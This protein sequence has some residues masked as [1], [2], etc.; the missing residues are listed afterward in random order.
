MRMAHTLPH[1][2]LDLPEEYGLKP[3]LLPVAS[4]A[5]SSPFH[6]FPI[7]LNYFDISL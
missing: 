3:I 1:N 6:V 7:F 4:S 2:P 5:R